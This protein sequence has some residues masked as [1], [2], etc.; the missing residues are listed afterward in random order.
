MTRALGDMGIGR[1][2]IGKFRSQRN[3]DFPIANKTAQLQNLRRGLRLLF[4]EQGSINLT[5]RRATVC[6]GTVEG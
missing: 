2:G 6:D 4:A 5:S 3:I 1:L